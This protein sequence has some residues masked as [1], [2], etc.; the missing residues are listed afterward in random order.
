MQVE[1]AFTPQSNFVYTSGV[2]AANSQFANL[3]LPVPVNMYER[4]VYLSL[5]SDVQ[6]S[7]FAFGFLNFL[8]KGQLKC[9]QPFNRSALGSGGELYFHQGIGADAIRYTESGVTQDILPITFQVACDTVSFTYT[10]NSTA[11]GD[12][13][14][15]FLGVLS[16]NKW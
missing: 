6:T 15:W 16:K 4:K 3:S 1:L 10:R 9:Q 7:Y 11:G 12:K 14:I 5:R 8:L 2:G 13:P